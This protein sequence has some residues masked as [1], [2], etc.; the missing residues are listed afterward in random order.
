MINARTVVQ[1][2]IF[3]A[4]AV[5]AAFADQTKTVFVTH[6]SHPGNFG[7]I[8]EGDEICQAEADDPSSVVPQGTYLA[9]LSDNEESPDTRFVKSTVPYVLP[10]GKMIA[11]N[12]A[13]LTDGSLMHQINMEPSGLAVG[14]Q[15]TWTGTN[16]DGTSAGDWL[17]CDGWKADPLDDFHGMGG[18]TERT[19][20]IWSSRIARV[21]CARQHRLW[22]FQ[23]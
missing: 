3:F 13:D 22:C 17:T 4:V 19:D 18:R 1:A 6:S 2:L 15:Y 10:N 16:S 21:G 11:K 8:A 7:G 9:W 5:P 14:T 20:G 12:Y 23:Q